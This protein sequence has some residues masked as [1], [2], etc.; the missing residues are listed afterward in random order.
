[1]VSLN[2]LMLIGN[3]GTDPEMRYTPNGK[4]VTTFRLAVTRHFNGQDGEPQDNTEWFTAVTWNAL[5]EQCSQWLTK[6]RRVFIE[7]RLKSNT[8]TGA[9]G[10]ARFGNEVI[11]SRVLFLD[12]GENQTNNPNQQQPAARQPVAAQASAQPPSEEDLPW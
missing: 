2:R 1:M 3:V 8:W 4:A 6:G 5:A 7:G 9:D 11:A 10:V 12:R